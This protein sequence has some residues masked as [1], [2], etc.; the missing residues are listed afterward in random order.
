MNQVVERIKSL[1]P[2]AGPYN[3]VLD[4]YYKLMH[5]EYGMEP[6]SSISA[7]SVCPDELNNQVTNY[8]QDYFGYTFH[9]GGLTG[10][11]FTGE[12]GFNAFGDHIP[13]DGT[14]VIFFGPHMAVDADLPLGLIRRKG[15]R[16]ATYSCGA[17]FSAHQ[18]VT[19]SPNL[20]N[21]ADDIQQ[22][23][24]KQMLA[25]NRHRIPEIAPELHILDLM[26][27]E[28]HEFIVRQSKRIKKKFNA[29]QIILLG[30]FIIN[31]PSDM[32]DYLTIKYFERV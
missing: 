22:E 9:I 14:A 28:S 23:A 2:Q 1:F 20:T 6:E 21:P 15:Q 11:P 7:V 32:P 17:A 5:D 19:G 29:R 26:F 4:S 13:D 27:E 10:Y 18:V 31:T 30:G 16:R 8:I 24:V 12:T 3:E 25:R